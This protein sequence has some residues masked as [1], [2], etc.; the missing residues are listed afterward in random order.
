VSGEGVVGEGVGPHF[1]VGQV[2]TSRDGGARVGND[3]EQCVPAT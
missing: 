1:D 2:V 3:G